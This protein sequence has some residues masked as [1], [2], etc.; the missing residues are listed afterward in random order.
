MKNDS[1][2]RSILAEERSCLAHGR[3]DDLPRI[4]ERKTAAL[5][6]LAE[7]A[8]ERRLPQ[9]RLAP[10]LVEARANERL[11]A[12]ALAGLRAAIGRFRALQEVAPALTAYTR[13]GRAV[14]HLSPGG[15]V[16]KKA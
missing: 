12:A 9:E 6:R 5:Q 2:L 7:Q 15:L 11:L 3:L 13:D 8:S 4:A 14:R 10:L 16:E 1:D